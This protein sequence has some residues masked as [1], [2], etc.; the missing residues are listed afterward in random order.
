MLQKKK[1]IVVDGESSL[2]IEKINW[3]WILEDETKKQPASANTTDNLRQ[4]T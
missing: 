1:H 4:A 2:N 3:V